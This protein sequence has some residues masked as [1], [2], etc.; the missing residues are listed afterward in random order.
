MPARRGWGRFVSGH[1]AF[2]AFLGGGIARGK[3]HELFAGAEKD[4]DDGASAAGFAAMLGL[5]AQPPGKPLLWLRTDA[6]ER[7]CGRLD[8]AGFAELGG[9]PASLVLARAPD[10]V[11]LLRGA[12][13]ALRCAGLGAVVI[14]CLG[15]P[16]TLDLTASRRLTLVAE[17]SGATGLLLRIGATPAPSAAETRWAV[18]AAPSAPLEAGAP[19]RPAL[20][21][22]LLRRRAGPAG[23]RWRVE[24]DR[25]ARCFREP[26]LSGAVLPLPLGGTAEMRRAAGGG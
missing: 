11:A 17:R 4:D 13:D 23:M 21:L 5:L 19:G 14:E 12:A 20:D 18:R 2:D 6:A 8:A 25:D 26:A 10:D 24:W 16:R 15:N 1:A 9:D 7:R 3:T 22:E